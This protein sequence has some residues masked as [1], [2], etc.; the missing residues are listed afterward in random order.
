MLWDGLFQL[1]DSRKTCLRKASPLFF[2]MLCRRWSEHP[3]SEGE[4]RLDMR[5]LWFLTEPLSVQGPRWRAR[6]A[7]IGPSCPLAGS[8]QPAHRPPAGPPGGTFPS[9][10]FPGLPSHREP[11]H[12]T[13]FKASQHLSLYVKGNRSGEEKRGME[14]SEGI[15]RLWSWGC[16]VCTWGRASHRN[17]ISCS[18]TVF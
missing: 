12:A 7:P 8:N 18:V 2:L 5:W 3:Q 14:L 11:S 15:L 4:W 16:L 6:W 1:H 17:G 13:P 9:S 10:A